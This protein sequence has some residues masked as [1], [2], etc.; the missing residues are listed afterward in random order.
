MAALIKGPTKCEVCS[1]MRFLTAKGERPAKIHKQ[2]VA[3]Y[4][5]IMNRQN[6]TK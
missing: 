1:V 6:V 2:I 3:V 5:N 4:G